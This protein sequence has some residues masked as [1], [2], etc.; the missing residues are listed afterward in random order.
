MLK[1]KFIY[2]RYSYYQKTLNMELTEFE[3]LDLL[4]VDLDYRILIWNSL[5]VILFNLRNGK[6]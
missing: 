4:K 2:K 1:S 6:F 3:D 5:Y